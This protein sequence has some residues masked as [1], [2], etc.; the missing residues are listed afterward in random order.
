MAIQGRGE[1]WTLAET[2]RAAIERA[3]EHFKQNRTHAAK[4]LGISIRTIRN[5]LAEYR[6]ADGLPA[7]KQMCGGCRKQ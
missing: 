4:A 5:K 6:E 2:E 3:L 1:I 7:L